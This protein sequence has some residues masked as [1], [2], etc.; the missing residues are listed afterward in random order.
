[1]RGEWGEFTADSA[2]KSRHAGRSARARELT[3]PSPRCPRTIRPGRPPER[4][5]VNTC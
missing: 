4:N 2:E 1:M 5:A 3:L